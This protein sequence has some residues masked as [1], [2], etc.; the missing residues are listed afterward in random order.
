MS[1]WE[2][3]PQNFEMELYDA[4][5]KQWIGVHWTKNN[6][7]QSI[8]VSAPWA[9]ADKCTKIRIKCWGSNLPNKQIGISR[10]MMTSSKDGGKAYLPY[11]DYEKLPFLLSIYPNVTK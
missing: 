8:A 6:R 1:S 3:Q 2:S 7:S 10:V 9:L 11:T 5:S 4:L